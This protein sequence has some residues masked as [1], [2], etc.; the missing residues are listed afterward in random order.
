M[1]FTITYQPQNRKTPR[2]RIELT[3]LALNIKFVQWMLARCYY[4]SRLD[5]FEEITCSNV[6]LDKLFFDLNSLSVAEVTL[7]LEIQIHVDCGSHTVRVAVE[8][9]TMLAHKVLEGLVVLST[10]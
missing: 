8:K 5:S 7:S 4:L 9:S 1:A 2:E 10:H 6:A 3:T